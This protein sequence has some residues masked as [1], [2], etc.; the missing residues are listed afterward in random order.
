MP[1]DAE[2][3]VQ[4]AF[5]KAWRNMAR[6]E[7]RSAFATWDTTGYV[8]DSGLE[9]VE[10]AARAGPPR[11]AARTETGERRRSRPSP[12]RRPSG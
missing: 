10:A 2:D 12:T 7:G 8:I 11:S 5:L 9:S 4:E 6:F 1:D 3:A